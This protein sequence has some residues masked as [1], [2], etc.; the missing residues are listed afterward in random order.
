MP[1]HRW[2]TDSTLLCHQIRPQMKSSFVRLGHSKPRM[3]TEAE[4]QTDDR[5][6]AVACTGQW[7][8]CAAVANSR[9]DSQRA[10]TNLCSLPVKV[11][12]ARCRRRASRTTCLNE[13]R[14]KERIKMDRENTFPINHVKDR[15]TCPSLH[16]INLTTR[17][18]FYC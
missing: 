18:Y 14:V 6:T 11:L 7:R 5:L 16:W 12:K 17:L 1:A 9:Q 2:A 13:M 15:T 3:E 4:V 8:S 10:D